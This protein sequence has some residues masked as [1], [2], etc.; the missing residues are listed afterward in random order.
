MKYFLTIL[1]L[2][3]FS[4]LAQAQEKAV[5]ADKKMVT[6]AAGIYKPFFETNDS[7]PLMV[8]AFKMDECAVTNA[9]FLEFVKANPAWRRSKV[10]RLFADSNYLKHWESDLS[11]GK[12]NANIYHSPV[13]NVSW[14]AAQAYC[15]WKNKRLPTIAEWELAG[16]GKPRNIKYTSLTEYILG[17]YKKPNPPVLPNVKT[18]YQN[19]YGLY[20]MHGLVWEW[21]FNFNSFTSKADS[22]GSTEDEAK[23]FCA[24]GSVKVKD[25]NDYAGFLRFSYRGSLKGNYCIPNLGFRCA[26]DIP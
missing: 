19:Q 24:A 26:K 11:I 9:E 3:V 17:W 16:N 4:G 22:R 15:K 7:R 2:T 18:T 14:F 1:L 6:V 25:K 13:V 10:N 20:D 23:A 8:A 21:T 5:I 12:I